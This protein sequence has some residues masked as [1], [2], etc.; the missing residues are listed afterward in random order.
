MTGSRPMR[1]LLR[2]FPGGADDRPSIFIQLIPNEAF[3]EG[4]AQRPGATRLYSPEAMTIAAAMRAAR[5]RLSV[6]IGA[7]ALAKQIMDSRGDF[8]LAHF[9]PARRRRRVVGYAYLNDADQGVRTARVGEL[10]ISENIGRPQSRLVAAALLHCIGIDE[11]K[12]NIRVDRRVGMWEGRKVNFFTDLKFKVKGV[13]EGE[14][15]PDAY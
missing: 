4:L 14:S 1:P 9:N 12:P 3:H 10:E 13:G 5:Q 6:P 2:E 15:D 11:D 8:Y 7:E